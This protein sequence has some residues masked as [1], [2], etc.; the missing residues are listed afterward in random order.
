MT[1]S[2][3]LQR[4][5]ENAARRL[6]PTPVKQ[7]KERADRGHFRLSPAIMR[8][9]AELLEGQEYP[10]IGSIQA[11]LATTCET[12]GLVSPSRAT[13]YKVMLRHEGGSYR[14]DKLPAAVQQALYNLSTE[15]I[16][17]GAQLAFYVFNYG[18]LAAIQ[19]ASGLPWLPLYQAQRM[20]G[21]RTKSQGLL[22]AV[23]AT[24]GI[25]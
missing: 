4:S 7:R 13:I 6:G 3:N 10:G 9:L 17:P 16:V 5:F 20:R 18:N 14:L 12:L 11:E 1:F 22:R 8:G 21:W 23:A 25:G 2:F 15:S 24:R 19:W